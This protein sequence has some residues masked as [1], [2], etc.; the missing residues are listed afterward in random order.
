MRI[1]TLDFESYWA[2]DYSLTRMSPLE[3]VMGDRYETISCSIKVDG[4]ATR[5]F[6]GHAAIAAEFDRLDIPNCALLGHNMLGFDCYVAAYRF[7]LRPKLWLDTLA[8][9]R[10]HHAKT[11]G[12]GLG[13][14]VTHYGL[15]VKNQAILLQT[16]G[17]Y[18]ADFTAL[19]VEQMR[20]YNGEDAD[21]CYALFQIL[22]KV[23]RA[24]ELW[25]I[26]MLVRQRTEPAFVL[27]A[28]LMRATLLQERANKRES[29]EELATLL[30]GITPDLSDMAGYDAIVEQV[31]ANMASAAKF[32][33]LLERLGVPVPMKE[34][35]SRPDSGIMVPALAKNDAEFVALQEHDNP[36]VRT[37]ATTR[38]AVKSTLLETRIEKFLTAA[39][40]AGGRL[41]VPIRYAGADTTG[42]DSGEEYNMLN[43]P[44][45]NPK[46]PKITDALR[47]S[48]G[49]R[50][51]E[52]IIVS[53]QSNIELRVN[54]T[55]WKVAKSMQLWQ[56][57]PDADLYQTFA[58]E[59]GGARQLAKVAQL[60]LGFG[61]GADTFRTVARDMS[62][63]EIDLSKKW[64]HA[65]QDEIDRVMT[66][67][68]DFEW[69]TDKQGYPIVYTHDPALELVQAW[70]AAYPEIV[71]G[72]ATCNEAIT[73]IANGVERQVDP[74]G[75]VHTSANGFELPGYTIRYPKLRQEPDT[76]NPR[77]RQWVYGEG[78]H[79][80][81]IYGPKAVENIVQSLA[82]HTIADNSIEFFRRTGLRPALR[83][84][85][86]LA[87][88]VP[89]ANSR[90]LLDELLAVM[91]TPPTWWPALRVWAKGNIGQTYGDSK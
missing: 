12:L 45:I 13:K 91:R 57:D 66:L 25:Q 23:T 54:H 21:Q 65:T 87:Y 8:M 26:D 70:R 88:V 2:T 36:V 80:A 60:G 43:L 27:D 18:L 83:P 68:P 90:E 58:D 55:L 38:L 59:I 41:P 84:Y 81:R 56:A 85:D 71:A 29:L 22:K 19:E 50:E 67:Q 78:R 5:V 40:L 39:S 9:A 74:W 31:R 6:F 7:G 69:P 16:K 79:K 20:T 24:D 51:D 48:L 11:T 42:R 33:A 30:T 15:G 82:R 63:G 75:L 49:V 32:A 89:R 73:W 35:P 76:R 1:I 64:R 61:S 53:D 34:S 14:L 77:R 86:E 3:Y 37:A 52:C 10:P 28:E 44:R 46:V 4:G 62:G 72:W 47:N 17:K